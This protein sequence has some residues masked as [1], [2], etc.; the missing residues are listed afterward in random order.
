MSETAV[1]IAAKLAI[2]KAKLAVLKAAFGS[3]NRFPA[4]SSKGGQFA[5]K[6][7]AG[8]G[9]AGEKHPPNTFVETGWA[10][11]G[12]WG[13]PKAPPAGS[14]PHPQVD[15]KGKPVHINYPTPASPANTWGNPKAVATFTPGGNTPEVLNGVPFKS[16]KPPKDGWAKVGGTNEK[17]DADFPFVPHPTKH[18]GAGVIIMEPDGRVW[19]TK[20]TNEFGGYKHTLPKGTAESGL[21]MQQNAIKEA[22]E[23]TGLK[24]KIVGIAA[25]IERDTSKAR[26]YF[27]R[28]V[29]GTPKDMGW[30]S[31]ALRLAPRKQALDL[32]NKPH[33]KSLLADSLDEFGVRKAKGQPTKADSTG[34]PGA[35]QFQE[36]WPGGSALGGQWK[37][38]GADGITA[39]PKIAGGLD[40]A[41]SIYQKVVNA[42]HDALQA[43][44]L[45]AAN[46]ALD[47]YQASADKFATG[48]KA[49]SH[50]KWGAQV[51]Q[52]VTQAKA[53]IKAKTTA[54]ATADK[55]TGPQKL[56]VMTP[57]GAKP[58]GSNP[59]GL[60]TDS[61]GKW[62]VKGSNAGDATP[63]SQNEVLASKLMGAVGVGAPDMKLV[64]L[65]GKHGG[66]IGVASKWVDGAQ[67]FN[68]S[69]AAHIAAAQADFVTHA[70]LANY[71]ALGMSMDNTVIKGG[72]A[73]NIDPGGALLYRAQ[74]APKGDAFGN[75]A[76][77]FDSMRDPAKN[78]NG[79]KVY[80]SMTASQL[81]ASAEKLKVIDDATI[82]KLVQAYGPGTDYDKGVLTAKLISRKA[83][84]LA[85]VAALQPQPAPTPKLAPASA[86]APAVAA[87]AAPTGSIT[88]KGEKLTF[89]EGKSNKF[90]QVAVVGT[91]VVTQWG[92]NGTEGNQT[93]K[94]MGTV[95][96]AAKEADKL[97]HSKKAKGYQDAGLVNMKVTGA[98]A[99]TI[100]ST[101]PSAPPTAAAPT[102]KPAKPMFTGVHA[103]TY[104]DV[105]D[106]LLRGD[107]MTVLGALG[108]APQGKLTI[109]AGG[110]KVTI[111]NPP[112]SPDG[113]ALFKLHKDLVAY[114]EALKAAPP[115]P[116]AAPASQIEK[117]TNW[118]FTGK[119][120]FYN[121]L[122][123]KAQS[124]HAASD[125]AG[126]K[127]MKFKGTGLMV[128]PANS[129]NGALM[130]DYHSKLVADL[131]AK[132]A[133][134]TM[135]AVHTAQQTLST[136]V[137]NP[138]KPGTTAP[139]NAAAMPDF[140]KAKLPTSNSNAASN[141]AKVDKI[142][143]LASKGDV[144]GLLSLNFGSNNY[145]KK[146]AQLANDALKALGSQHSVAAGQKANSH[147]ALFGGQSP[148]NVAAAAGKTKQPMP[149]SHPATKVK[150]DP[151]K[152]PATPVFVTSNAAVKSEN[153]GHAQALLML[154]TK[155][156]L[157]ALKDYDKFSQKSQKLTEFK[158]GLIESLEQQLFPPRGKSGVHKNPPPIGVA[159]TP[160]K[161]LSDHAAHFAPVKVTE[162]YKVTAHHKICRLCRAWQDGRCHG[163]EGV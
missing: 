17:L 80:G 153:E 159:K 49:S 52:Y 21:T 144:K 109:T 155:G 129:A 82:G 72:K 61:E 143:E 121:D 105:A 124:L 63:R 24:V 67:A 29:G 108:T 55:L 74:G 46:A 147:P 123:D 162:A 28:R 160:L 157:K 91:K 116:T 133:T 71:D 104:S 101:A 136:P 128:W 8:G 90:W 69:N 85:R 134:A 3:I 81:A 76:D 142:A 31:Q 113:K 39:P 47:K 9:A 79:A 7:T 13:K 12:M 44:D 154:G 65:E 35:W 59:G 30:E 14:K 135:Q 54:T 131:E 88:V 126:L 138:P 45:K 77:E 43:G 120:Q 11:S 58:G 163:D 34:K 75:K 98:A 38:M 93:F 62:L 36:R 132:Q 107:P 149:A 137:Q 161:A 139:G 68:A 151:A 145:A 112:K 60:Y 70:W 22:F 106:G 37:A 95:K 57:A 32:L 16:W 73:I 94:D 19:L 4:G 99:A 115:A 117:P 111:F 42:A 125:L 53:D 130:T 20:P 2:A 26:Y 18:T 100:T 114:H 92:K 97:W 51:H 66:G 83:D 48:A 15:D 146:Q 140:G 41:N 127:A 96:A 10:G 89:V 110:N 148:V 33:D 122:T 158:Q 141:N 1:S 150:V 56:S 27:A 78:P 152:F 50:V 64:D 6:G 5:P 87:P 25:D 84:I 102:V 156:D 40:G 118:P 23:E 86:P 119:A 103:K